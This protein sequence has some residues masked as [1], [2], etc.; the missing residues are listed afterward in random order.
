M[1]HVRINVP[2]FIVKLLL[3]WYTHQKMCV[4]WGNSTSQ[5]FLVG[6]GVKQALTKKRITFFDKKITTQKKSKLAHLRLLSK[7]NCL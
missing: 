5:D 4:R 3:F 7:S 6:N 2:L 1:C